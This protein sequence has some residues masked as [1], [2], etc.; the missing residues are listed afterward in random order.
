[1]STEPK[2][3][4]HELILEKIEKKAR[5]VLISRKA[6]EE[7]IE[8]GEIISGAILPKNKLEEIIVRIEKISI[9]LSPNPKSDEKW[10]HDYLIELATHLRKGVAQRQ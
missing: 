6:E 1:M 7:M 3:P 2:K 5:K 10:A 9:I 8:F 4:F